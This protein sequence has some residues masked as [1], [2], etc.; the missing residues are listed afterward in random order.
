MDTR[1]SQQTRDPS[2]GGH[3][4]SAARADEGGH[5]RRHGSR[6]RSQRSS[7]ENRLWS[8]S[9]SLTSMLRHGNGG[10][11]DVLSSSAGPQSADSVVLGTYVTWGQKSPMWWR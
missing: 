5:D 9:K 8:I 11:C 4:G 2:R 10:A 7:E 3:A 1:T 6:R